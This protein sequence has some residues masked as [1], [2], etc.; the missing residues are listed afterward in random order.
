MS[1][2]PARD[3]PDSSPADRSRRQRRRPARRRDPSSS[4]RD[5]AIP[6]SSDCNR[7]RKRNQGRAL[8]RICFSYNETATSTMSIRDDKRTEKGGREARRSLLDHS[9]I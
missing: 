3:S 8:F 5:T 9:M 2:T 1:G 4:F 6:R 7:E